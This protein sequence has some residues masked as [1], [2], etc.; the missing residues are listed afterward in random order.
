MH[1][2]ASW[3]P[4]MDGVNPG[5]NSR[6]QTNEACR[7]SWGD[8]CGQHGGQVHPVT[9]CGHGRRASNEFTVGQQRNGPN[10]N[11]PMVIASVPDWTGQASPFWRL[12]PIRFPPHDVTRPSRGLQSGQTSP[13]LGQQ[14]NNS[15]EMLR[16]VGPSA[17]SRASSARHKSS[18]KDGRHEEHHQ[19]LPR[20]S[21]GATGCQKSKSVPT[22]DKRSRCFPPSPP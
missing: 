9:V 15:L 20:G 5:W 12:P 4:W 8:L 1:T 22:F 21:S 17:V 13:D 19:N 2:P 18:P 11:L 14:R 6:R 7:R 3:S 16:P 10:F